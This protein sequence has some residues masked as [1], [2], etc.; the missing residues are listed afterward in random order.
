MRMQ[1]IVNPAAAGGRLGREWPRLRARLAAAGLECE[2]RLTEAPGHAA[3]LAARAAAEGACRVLVAGGDGTLCEAAEG[4]A[5]SGNSCELAI[6][7]MGTGNDAARTLGLDRD[8]E[9]VVRTALTGVPRAVDLIRVGDRL[10]LN[11]IG[12]GLTADINERAARIKGMRGIGVYLVTAMVSVIKFRTSPV[13]LESDEQSLS[14]SMAIL[15]VHNGPTTGGGFAL[16]P[17][18][19]PDDG[20]FDVT[21]VPDVL[22][23]GRLSRLAAALRGTLNN[24][25]GTVAFRTRSLD[26]HHDE[27][28]AI[29]FDG[30]E[31]RIEGPVT[32]FEIV[33]K[34]LKIV[35]PR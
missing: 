33:P 6:Y 31:G 17:G 2:T 14:S 34:A 22:F 32:R 1:V 4:L 25:E 8:L 29:H 15:A 11:A 7:P 16:T 10:V 28:L 5:A 9:S 18:A 19:V 23:F 30:N 12:I 13:R 21:L 3:E 35:V 26:L 24:C 27:P 20:L